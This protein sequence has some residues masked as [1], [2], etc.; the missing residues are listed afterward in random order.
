MIAV[1]PAR[2]AAVAIT[3]AVAAEVLVVTGVLAVGENAK[4]IAQ[5]VAVARINVRVVRAAPVVPGVLDVQTVVQAATAA[6]DV[7]AVQDHVPVLAKAAAEPVPRTA[8]QAA[9]EDVQQVVF[10]AVLV[11]ATPTAP[12][13]ARTTAA[14]NAL[15]A[16]HLD[17]PHPAHQAASIHLWLRD[18]RCH[19]DDE[20]TDKSIK[21]IHRCFV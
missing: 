4:T 14:D 21:G 8:L 6:M 19:H 5:A 15:Q 3:N 16:V 11:Y 12:V 1:P 17:A 10:R 2:P 9:P 20:R 7:R 18:R 13:Y